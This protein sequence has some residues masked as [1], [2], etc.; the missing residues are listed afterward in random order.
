MVS[1]LSFIAALIFGLLILEMSIFFP[2]LFWLS[3]V[4]IVAFIV[5]RHYRMSLSTRN[6]R[7]WVT[8]VFQLLWFVLS[9]VFLVFIDMPIFQ[10]A[11]VLF[12][13][14]LIPFNLLFLSV[15]VVPPDIKEKHQSLKVQYSGFLSLLSLYLTAAV[16]FALVSILLVSPFI[17][18]LFLLVCTLFFTWM[19]L[20]YHHIPLKSR[21]IGTIIPS[22]V[23]VEAFAALTL[24][25]ATVF[26]VAG[27]W[28]LSVYIMLGIIRQYLI[29]GKQGFTKRILGRYVLLFVLGFLVIFFTT[30]WG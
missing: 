1:Y 30:R 5:F 3:S 4:I 23:A 20:E 17:M 6:I 29:F 12:M 14:L 28:M 27:L 22:L 16:S 24:W 25:P 15:S 21:V 7:F 18:A 9:M 10:H 13:S 19:W 8:L 11:W 2:P 26:A